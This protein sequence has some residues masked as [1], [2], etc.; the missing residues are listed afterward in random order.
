MQ[1][2]VLL[3]SPFYTPEPISNL[4]KVW[5]KAVYYNRLQNEALKDGINQYIKCFEFIHLEGTS[6]FYYTSIQSLSRNKLFMLLLAES[7]FVNYNDA[8]DLI[9]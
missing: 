4:I 5:D 3:R 8:M 1:G 9:K 2:L 6:K 7:Y